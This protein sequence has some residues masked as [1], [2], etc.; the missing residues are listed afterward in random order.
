MQNKKLICSL[1]AILCFDTNSIIGS[2]KYCVPYPAK[3]E[4]MLPKD[5]TF[6]LI[7]QKIDIFFDGEYNNIP[8]VIFVNFKNSDCIAQTEGETGI[9]LDFD[10]FNVSVSSDAPLSLAAHDPYTLFTYILLH[11]AGHLKGKG[12][13]WEAND[14]A[15]KHLSEIEID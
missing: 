9:A 1:I 2:E 13:E 6:H 14:Y 4:N 10:N 7:I 3:K 5:Q 15:S 12:E 8:E 11:E